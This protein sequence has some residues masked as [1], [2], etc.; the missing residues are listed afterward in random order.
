MAV[1]FFPHCSNSACNKGQISVKTELTNEQQ[2]KIKDIH[3]QFQNVCMISPVS[4]HFA[5]WLDRSQLDRSQ[6]KSDRAI[7]KVISLPY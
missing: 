2:I 6:P 7:E 4:D 5:P 3:L 1:N